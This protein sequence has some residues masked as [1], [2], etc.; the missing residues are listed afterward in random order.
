MTFRNK[1]VNSFPLILGIDWIRQNVQKIDIQKQRLEFWAKV[2][3]TKI[4]IYDE[5]GRA[6]EESLYIRIIHSNEISFRVTDRQG[7]YKTSQA[8]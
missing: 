7:D 4:Y 1:Q 5:Q 8:D 3:L 6:M 2:E